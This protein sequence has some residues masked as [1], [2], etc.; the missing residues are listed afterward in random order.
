MTYIN[1]T[2]HGDYWLARNAWGHGLKLPC[3]ETYNGATLEI[4]TLGTGTHGFTRRTGKKDPDPKM[5]EILALMLAS[6]ARP[7]YLLDT[8]R[9]GEG[10]Q[11]S[12]APLEFA[13]QIPGLLLSSIPYTFLHLP[14]LAPSIALRNDKNLCWNGF[15]ERYRQE[16]TK[17]SM[18]VGQ[19]FVEA[20][21]ANNGLPILLCAENYRPDFDNLG[22][23]EQEACYCHRFTLARCMAERLSDTYD[24]NMRVI[25][26][27]LDMAAFMA[28][29]RQGQ[30]YNPAQHQFSRPSPSASGKSAASE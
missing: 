14:C 18:N 23:T 3:R 4:G 17:E 21:A 24:H 6:I 11:G 27:D 2:K 29:R 25:R 15:R 7:V 5:F 22:V 28:A 30:P 10:G 9:A 8:R 16:L 13:T 12:W 19:A 26:K 1:A 20:A